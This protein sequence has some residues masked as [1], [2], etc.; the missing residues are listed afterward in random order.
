[1][2]GTGL[3]GSSFFPVKGRRR[4]KKRKKKE[5]EEK[6]TLDIVCYANLLMRIQPRRKTVEKE[7]K[8]SEMNDREKRRK[9]LSKHTASDLLTTGCLPPSSRWTMRRVMTSSFFFS[10]FNLSSFFLSS[11]LERKRQ[12][13]KERDAKLKTEGYLFLCLPMRSPFLLLSKSP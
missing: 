2:K 6:M 13:K 3:L 8:E 4:E 11:I 1:M 5:K 9:K 12:R 7:R 10:L